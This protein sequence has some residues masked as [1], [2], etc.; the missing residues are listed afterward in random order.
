MAMETPLN[1]FFL[2]SLTDEDCVPLQL[3]AVRRTY[4]ILDGMF[5]AENIN[6]CTI[7]KY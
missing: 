3:L 5:I 4:N 6:V 2:T 7:E 1:N